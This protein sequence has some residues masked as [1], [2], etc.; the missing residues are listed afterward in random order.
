VTD[1]WRSDAADM[2]VQR[3]PW[4]IDDGVG[5]YRGEA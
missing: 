3:D 5:T 2:L 4:R 1:R